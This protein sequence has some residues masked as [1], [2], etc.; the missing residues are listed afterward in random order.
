MSAES[1]KRQPLLGNGSVNTPDA[2]QWLSR[3]YVMAARYRHL[4]PPQ[5]GL[6]VI[7]V[8]VTLRLTVRQSVRNGV[9]PHVG[10]MTWYLL[11]FESYGPVLWGTLS[12]E[13]TGLSFVY[14]A[15]PCQCSL[16]RVRVPCYSRPYF[17]VSDL[18]LPFSSPPTTC[19]VTVEVFDPA[20]TR[21]LPVMV[22]GPHYVASAR[23]AHKT[24]LPTGRNIIMILTLFSRE[25]EDANVT[26]S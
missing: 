8:R 24:P 4:T 25:C 12:D 21:V 19:R 7:R 6:P 9:E 3:R 1:Q 10:L 14:A 26:S 17:T 11:L 23:T 18:R 22:A 13:R 2:M 16:S 20:S 15:V 5:Y